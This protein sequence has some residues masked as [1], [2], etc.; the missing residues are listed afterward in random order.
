MTKYKKPL[1]HGEKADRLPAD[2]EDALDVEVH[3]EV[4]AV[5]EVA[6][7]ATSKEELHTKVNP[8]I[9]PPPVVSTSKTH[10]GLGGRYRAIGGGLKVP[11]SD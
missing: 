8:V 3:D 2:S 11:V 6:D 9:P 10:K 5:A 4:E 7:E 1:Y